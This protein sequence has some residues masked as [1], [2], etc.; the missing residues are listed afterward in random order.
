MFPQHNP[1]HPISRLSEL[2]DALRAYFDEEDLKQLALDLRVDY[3]DL[4][5]DG[6]AGKARALVEHLLRRDRLVEL[7]AY[8]RERRP[9]VAWPAPEALPALLAAWRVE[10]PELTPELRAYLET[11]AGQT[12]RVLLGPLDPGGRE[13]AHVALASIFIHLHAGGE[14]FAE[15]TLPNGRILR[16]LHQAALAH[17]HHHRRLILL[18]DPGSGKTTLLRFLAF[19][20]AQAALEPQAGW[21]E[22]LA[23]MF[24]ETEVGQGDAAPRRAGAPPRRQAPAGGPIVVGGDAGPVLLREEQKGPL[25]W[26]AAAPLPLFVRLGDFARTPFDPASPSAL[27]E[28][29]ARWLAAHDL[30]EAA[31]ALQAAARR[32]G[33]IFLLDGV[34]EVPPAQRAA[35]WR[36][37]DAL[38]AGPYRRSRWV[39]TCRVL[40]FDRQEAPAGVP[41]Q[42]LEPLNDAQVG[43]FIR[44]W[45]AALAEMGE[46]N[47]AEAG[48]LAGSLQDAAARANLA[49]LARN[50]MLLT[51]MALVQ[52]Y[53]GALPEERAKLYQACVETL[54]LRWQGRKE[55]DQ[56]RALPEALQTL[57]VSQENLERL[58]WELA[59]EAHSRVL[60]RRGAADLAESEVMQIAA[61]R[62]GSYAKAEAFVAY[63][64]KRAHLLIGRGGLTQRVYGFPHRTFQEYLAACHIAFGRRFQRRACELAEQGE[65]WREVLVLA[66]GALLFVGKKRLEVLDALDFMLRKEPRPEHAGDWSRVWLAAEMAQ[67]LKLA[68]IE[69]DEVGRELLPRLRAQ[70][71]ALVRGGRL[72]PVQRAAAGRALAVLGDPREGVGVVVRD[73]VRLPDIAWGK[74][75][76]AGRYSIGGDAEAF[77]SFERR[78][79][80]IAQPFRLARYPVTYAQFQCFVEAADFEDGR[81]WAGMPEMAKDW[82]DPK[83]PVREIKPQAFPY[84][85]HPR[86]NV[87]WYQA[88]AFCRWLSAYLEADIR[89]PHEYEWE[90]AARYPDGRFYPW[91]ADFDG[92]KANTNEGE[93]GSTTAVGSYPAGRQPELDL[94]DLSGNVWEW[95]CNK[96][97]DPEDDSVDV[98]GD[99]RAL[100]GGSWSSSR[101]SARAAYRYHAHPG[102]RYNYVGLRLVLARRPPSHPDH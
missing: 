75:A 44:N 27:W 74:E 50:P 47:A 2:I 57:E 45:Y 87:S 12:A 78:E 92:E 5:G 53:Y 19:C 65:A 52:T 89:L 40:S 20:L 21:L 76:P 34:D 14:V 28:H 60:E 97:D 33:V 55:L 26:S 62:L 39:A 68:D 48:A 82:D 90:A 98:D 66:T 25:R 35:V 73:G 8:A 100:R 72:T 85:N 51:I 56:A 4:A 18:G 32:G 67:V 31:P 10:P 15:E 42:T 24:W 77:D 84:T 43:E 93:I 37:V 16:R 49:E 71:A 88:V 80:D 13:S 3:A 36:A 94:Y 54:L 101:R 86:E 29:A 83:Y 9:Q 6:K 22:R 1:N 23:W 70:L 91:G 63:T 95:C 79:V 30:A 59:W 61:R 38:A 58:L 99:W 17:V 64:E 7:I 81:W 46:I 11:V 102:A 96:Y 41:A 69:S